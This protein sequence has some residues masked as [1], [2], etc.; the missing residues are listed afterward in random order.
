MMI[1]M[2]MMMMIFQVELR[3]AGFSLNRYQNEFDFFSW[4][5]SK[6]HSLSEISKL[7]Y[8]HKIREEGV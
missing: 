7:T 3:N 2:T 8:A 6:G 4:R 5:T 1:L